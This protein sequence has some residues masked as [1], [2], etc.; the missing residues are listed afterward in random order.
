[1]FTYP[2]FQKQR[3]NPFRNRD[4]KLQTLQQVA[5][6]RRARRRRR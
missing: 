4:P 2:I 6:V 3:G 5:R 1:V